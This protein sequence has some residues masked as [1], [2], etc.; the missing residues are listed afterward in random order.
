VATAVSHAQALLPMIEA[1]YT[2]PPPAGRPFST[3]SVRSKA[4][5]FARH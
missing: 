5:P 4:R 3:P 1:G 2:E